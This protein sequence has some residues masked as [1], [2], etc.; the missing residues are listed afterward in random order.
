MLSCSRL[1]LHV[2]EDVALLVSCGQ[3]EGQGRVVALQHGSVIVQDGQLAPGVAQE[4]VGSSRVIH[5]MNGGR[6]ERSG[7]IDWI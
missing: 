2:S 4:R 7:L 3:L 1:P 5:V 6:D